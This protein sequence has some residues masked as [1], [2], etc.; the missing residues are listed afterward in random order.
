[1]ISKYAKVRH[2][3]I[4]KKGPPCKIQNGPQTPFVVNQQGLPDGQ[5]F[6]KAVHTPDP[7]LSVLQ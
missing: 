1:M 5:S 6:W 4:K 7:H 2:I 3:L